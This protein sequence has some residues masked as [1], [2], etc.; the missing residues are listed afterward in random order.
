MAIRARI[1][2]KSLEVKEACAW[3]CALRTSQLRTRRDCLR[4]PRC[5]L[6]YDIYVYCSFYYF[7]YYVS[8]NYYN[9]FRLC[10]LATLIYKLI[11]WLR[12][13]CGGYIVRVLLLPSLCSGR[14]KSL[15]NC[16]FTIKVMFVFRESVF[17]ECS[18]KL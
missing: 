12:R 5:N 16:I 2:P 3:A 6:Y 15:E 18:M 14:R 17:C 1:A 9:V 8:Y 7:F 11:C 4:A 13:Y 10:V